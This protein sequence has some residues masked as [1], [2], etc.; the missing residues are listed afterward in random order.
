M[1]EKNFLLHCDS[2]TKDF[3]LCEYNKHF[4][5]FSGVRR[6]INYYNEMTQNEILKYLR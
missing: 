5:K 3:K 2:L 4:F 1:I 6:L